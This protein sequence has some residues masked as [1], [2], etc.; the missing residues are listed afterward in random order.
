M[1]VLKK[2]YKMFANEIYFIIK[3]NNLISFYERFKTILMLKMF[4]FLQFF[5]TK[6]ANIN[7]YSNLFPT[8]CLLFSDYLNFI[9][10]K[11][12]G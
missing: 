6:N 9:L 4:K 5:L 7:F 8:D 2:R 10:F 1:L 12:F 11:L 3:K